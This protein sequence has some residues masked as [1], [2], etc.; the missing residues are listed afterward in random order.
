[1]WPGDDVILIHTVAAQ[2]VMLC[3]I[4]ECFQSFFTLFSAS[5]CKNMEVPLDKIYNKTLRDKF[6]W[7]IDMTENDFVF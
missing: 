7:A 1:M 2:E 6:A 3:F 4:S 5:R